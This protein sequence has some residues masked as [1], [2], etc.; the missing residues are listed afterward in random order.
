LE[1][2]RITAPIAGTV[3][4]MNAKE[5]Q[6]LNANQQTPVILRIA[7]LNMMTVWSQISEA[8]VTQ[9]KSGQDAY[10]TLLGQ[11]D[12]RWAGTIRQIMP[13]PEEINTVV[14]YP[15][16]F[17]VPNPKHE[18]FPRM[19]AQVFIILE[20]AENATLVPVSALQK[21]SRPA[22]GVPE[23]IS[24]PS[25]FVNVPRS[26]GP[27]EARPVNVG[28]SNAVFVQITS[29]LREGET[30]VTGT[31]PPAGSGA[32]KNGLGSGKNMGAVR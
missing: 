27:A 18:L 16:L 4:M 7:D 15:V 5:G 3:L 23:S 13:M 2:T 30:V 11:L 14:F 31:R 28:I 1:Y 12:R 17:D 22:A 26:D 32:P 21:S 19:T 24:S 9:V 25:Y 10:F 20:K 8:D 6:T 29:G